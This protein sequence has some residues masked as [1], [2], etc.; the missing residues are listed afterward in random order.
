MMPKRFDTHFYLAE[1]PSAQIGAHDG[2]ESVESI[3]IGPQH[4]LDQAAAG[5]MTII[6]PTRMNLQKLAPFNSVAEA[7]DAARKSPVV[8]V[9]PWV[10]H[11]EGKQYLL[12]PGDA[13]YGDVAEPLDQAFR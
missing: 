1:A 4:A 5:H 11:R 2:Q 3:W 7:I 10:E 8:T 9:T 13:G 12:I 6:F